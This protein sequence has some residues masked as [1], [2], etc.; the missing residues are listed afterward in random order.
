M[1]DEEHLAAARLAIG[2]QVDCWRP[3]MDL[4]NISVDTESC[5]LPH[6]T[7]AHVYSCVATGC[8]QLTTPKEEFDYFFRGHAPLI[9]IGRYLVVTGLAMA[10][11]GIGVYVLS[12][13]STSFLATRGLV[14]FAAGTCV[15]LLQEAVWVRL[16]W[17]D[18]SYIVVPYAFEYGMEFLAFLCVGCP[19]VLL[20]QDG[21]PAWLF[22]S[23]FILVYILVHQFWPRYFYHYHR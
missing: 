14:V 3:R 20:M 1:S 11:T 5:G 19:L 12:P 10:F 6:C 8:V 15:R 9:A 17:D 23:S 21:D 22:L 2:D 7:S 13:P 4:S 16:T 18:F